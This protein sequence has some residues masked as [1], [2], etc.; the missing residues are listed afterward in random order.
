M[1]MQLMTF[2]TCSGH[3]EAENQNVILV[4]S[5]TDGNVAIIVA[6]RVP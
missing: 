4:L 3:N 1:S 6:K 2:K 5:S